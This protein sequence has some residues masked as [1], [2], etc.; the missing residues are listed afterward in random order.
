M[1]RVLLSIV[2]ASMPLCS[3][4]S[5]AV[6]GERL[7]AARM[8]GDDDLG[9]AHVDSAIIALLSQAPAYFAKE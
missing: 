6:N 1:K 4:R 3:K 5:V 8:L 2:T 7:C 9:A